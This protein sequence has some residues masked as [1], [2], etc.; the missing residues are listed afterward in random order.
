MLAVILFA[1]TS[2]RLQLTGVA[3]VLGAAVGL[4]L[5]D[6]R[7]QLMLG[8]AGS[9]VIGAAAGLGVV[10]TFGSAIRILVLIGLI[11]LNIASERVSFSKVIDSIGPLRYLDR[12][13]RSRH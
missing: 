2:D 12:I 1:S 8:D 5:F 13:G 6:L 10:L 9:N 11:A 7:E 4:L 3:I